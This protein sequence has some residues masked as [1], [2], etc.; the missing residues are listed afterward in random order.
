[1]A[2]FWQYFGR[3][4]RRS[5]C[6][7]IGAEIPF[8]PAPPGRRPNWRLRTEEVTGRWRNPPAGGRDRLRGAGTA[9]SRRDRSPHDQLKAPGSNG[10]LYR[11]RW[12]WRSVRDRKGQLTR[13]NPKP[14]D[15]ALMTGDEVAARLGVSRAT[16]ERL[17][18]RRLIPAIRFSRKLIRYRWQDVESAMEKVTLRA[19]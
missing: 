2:V 7:A 13:M 9:G 16:V 10:A 18:K 6:R 4:F 12:P 8:S 17:R 1:M 3:R 15:S 5:A 14:V 19:I 11:P